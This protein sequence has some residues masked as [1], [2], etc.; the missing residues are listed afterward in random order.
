MSGADADGLGLFVSLDTGK[1][2]VRCAAPPRCGVGV[3][4]PRDSSVA[5]VMRAVG[6][7]PTIEAW[8]GTEAERR[9]LQLRDEWRRLGRPRLD[10]YALTVAEGR[11]ALDEPRWVLPCG[12]FVLGIRL[13]AS[14]PAR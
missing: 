8:G 1:A 14:G 6:G 10:D 9:L 2:R 7:P 13:G 11:G 5:C 3:F 12:D 4:S